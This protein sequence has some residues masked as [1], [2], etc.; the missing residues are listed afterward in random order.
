MHRST[1]YHLSKTSCKKNLM[2]LWYEIFWCLSKCPGWKKW[3][4]NVNSFN[5]E[6]FCCLVA[7]LALCTVSGLLALHVSS[8]C[9]TR[10]TCRKRPKKD[11]QLPFI[12]AGQRFIVIP[13]YVPYDCFA[14]VLFC[15]NIL[16]LTCA[17]SL[18][19]KPHH[20]KQNNKVLSA[21]RY[22]YCCLDI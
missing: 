9:R 16:Y 20:N 21:V 7:I 17:A 22:Y 13:S 10:V 14:V 19:C 18:A 3:I 4:Y 1:Q 12:L 5:W 2:L 6:E 15:F 8:G 11:T